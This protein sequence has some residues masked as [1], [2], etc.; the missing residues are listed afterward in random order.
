[1]LGTQY[2]IVERD[3]G[4]DAALET[5]DGYCDY[6]TKTIVVK[7]LASAPGMV[8]DLAKYRK[9]VLRHELTHA[10]LHECGLSGESWAANEEIVDWIALQFPKLAAVF[11][12]AKAI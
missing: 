6:T 11:K 8:T 5:A 7:R 3:S 9:D 12:A 2:I 1:M 4:S 10:L